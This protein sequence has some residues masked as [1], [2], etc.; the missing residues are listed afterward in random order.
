MKK[1]E[2]FLT[3]GVTLIII[4]VAFFLI[5]YLVTQTS[6][7]WAYDAETGAI[8]DTIGGTVGPVV[9]FIGVILTFLAFYVQYDAN[10]V[11]RTALYMDQFES[12]FF[13]LLRMH[14]ENVNRIKYDQTEG[15][16]ALKKLAIE[17][18]SA[19]KIGRKADKD[20][21]FND[22][23]II[24]IAFYYFYFGLSAET[25]K[26][27]NES[28]SRPEETDKK[29]ILRRINTELD[30]W[31]K[32][33]GSGEVKVITDQ[34]AKLEIYFK[35]IFHMFSFLH[36]QKDKL[37]DSD[38]RFFAETIVSQ[39]TVHEITLLLYHCLSE[40]GT[41]WFSP[42]NFVEEYD[43]TGKLKASLDGVDKD[44]LTTIIN[45]YA[46]SIQHRPN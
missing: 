25:K 10:K 18:Q 7:L 19:F 43:L 6:S 34:E 22:L 20:I 26:H 33:I 32:T 5:P 15:L 14:R 1:G 38:R 17:V 29:Q 16:I 45:E 30:T 42:I 8:G 27:I 44:T 2:I 41:K 35:H 46:E 12:K 24:Q 13:E 37:S 23:T 11:Q 40:I 3:F 9:G 31:T 4:G 36:Q 39:F 21:V 28:Y